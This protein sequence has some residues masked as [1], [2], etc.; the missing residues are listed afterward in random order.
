MRGE[1]VCCLKRRG[2]R[3]STGN[4]AGMRTYAV[5]YLDARSGV[6]TFTVHFYMDDRGTIG[7]SGLLDPKWIFEDGVI[8][9]SNRRRAIA[10]T[11]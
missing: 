2:R 5:G 8:Y 1:Y 10:D 6:P 11:M 4:L 3:K 9:T 7:A